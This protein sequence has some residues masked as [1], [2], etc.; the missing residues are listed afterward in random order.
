[1]ILRRHFLALAPLAIQLTAAAWLMAAEPKGDLWILS[2][3]SNAC[4]RAKLP[5]PE[6]HARVTAF[7]PEQNDFVPAR[8]PLPNMGTVGVGPWVAAA[9]LVAAESKQP[10]RLC[11]FASGGKP[12]AFWHPGE[13]GH[14][15]LFPV[16]EQAGQEADVFLWYQGEND[17]G[18]RLTTAEYRRELT[19]HV[20]RVREAAGNADMLAVIVQLGPSLHGGRGGYMAL[21][22]AQRQFVMHDA[23]AVLVPALGRTL[24]DSVHLDNAGYRELGREIGRAVL[25]VRHQN[26]VG[27]WPGPVLDAAVLQPDEKARTRTAVAAHFAEV[28]ALAH[29]EV[30]DFAVIDAEGTNRAVELEAGKTVVRL[31]CE[32][33][34]V[35]PARLVYGLGTK[36]TASLTDEA[37]NRAPAVQIG[38]TLGEPPEDVPTEASNGAG[39][40]GE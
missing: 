6:P 17:T 31:T 22:E 37:G 13:P 18:G 25:E 15:G 28:Q 29:A 16:I 12:I 27:D 34:V 38:I 24:K 4:G 19:E 23:H 26:P 9:N 32:R 35:L 36:P 5:G 10:V 20:A 3:Q 2:G 14:K 11:G 21:R 7:A 8:D 30:S 40:A 39:R 33:D 1:M